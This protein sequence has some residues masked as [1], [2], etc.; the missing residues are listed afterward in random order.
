MAIFGRLKTTRIQGYER[1]RI[2]GRVRWVGGPRVTR[3]RVRKLP[4]FYENKC[5]I[6]VFVCEKELVLYF[7]LILKKNII[8]SK[9]IEKRTITCLF[10]E[11]GNYHI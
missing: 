7:L 4:L 8:C 6:G 1:S 11:D 2:R 10:K 9:L 3:G 5:K